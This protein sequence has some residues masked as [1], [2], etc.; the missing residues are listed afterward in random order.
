[1]RKP[2]RG[3][4]RARSDPS[5]GG[6]GGGG[7]DKTRREGQR[8]SRRYEYEPEG[9]VGGR[10]K[11]PSLCPSRRPHGQATPTICVQT[12]LIGRVYLC[13]K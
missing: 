12:D 4:A 2:N 11:G 8:G 10:A 5:G 13:K 3:R 6:G 9:K 1:M 7:A